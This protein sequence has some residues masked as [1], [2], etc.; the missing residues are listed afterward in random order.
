MP[1]LISR[2]TLGLCVAVVLNACV[3]VPDQRHYA[4]GVVMLA[5]PP[6]REEIV[7]T[8][9]APGYVWI[10]GYWGWMGDR[11]E[12]LAGHWSAPRPGRHWVPHQWIRQGDGWRLR[13]GH[14]A[15][16]G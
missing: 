6:Q 4:D 2:W 9:P 16:D 7:G 11:H 8:A 5:P 10:N 13:P 1:A 15:R 14:W 12:W 3:I